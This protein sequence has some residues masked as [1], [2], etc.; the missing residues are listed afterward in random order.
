M[1]FLALTSCFW[2]DRGAV[3]NDVAIRTS[4]DALEVLLCRDI[5]AT[6]ALMEDRRPGGQWI[7]FVEY[8]GDPLSFEAGGV[9]S[10]SRTGPFAVAAEPT[11]V[12]GA[13]IAIQLGARDAD[14]ID[15]LFVVPSDG[16]SAELWL[17]PDGLSS[18]SPCE[19]DA[20]GERESTVLHLSE[21]SRQ[22]T[23]RAATNLLSPLVHET[24]RHFAHGSSCLLRARSQAASSG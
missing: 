18:A 15:S 2:A 4:E 11:L 10:L 12:P 24:P 23:L 8:E 3:A 1:L 22:Q 17:K 21:A 13:E 9:I 14:V 5:V 16:L 19:G 7:P 20:R 6:F